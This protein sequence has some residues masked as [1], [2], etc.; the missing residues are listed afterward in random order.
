M[1]SELV[2]ESVN[3]WM[4]RWELCLVYLFVIMNGR[5]G[6]R[7]PWLGRNHKLPL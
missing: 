3:E 4:R 5:E 2:N 7:V 6:V 1:I